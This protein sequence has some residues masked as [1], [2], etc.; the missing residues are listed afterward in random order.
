LRRRYLIDLGL[1]GFRACGIL[2]LVGQVIGSRSL[3]LTKVYRQLVLAD[4]RPL[5]AVVLLLVLA[6]IR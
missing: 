6:A 1:T 2:G 5:T 4:L 3:S